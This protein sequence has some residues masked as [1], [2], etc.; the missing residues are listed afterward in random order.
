MVRVELIEYTKDGEKVVAQ[1]AKRTVSISKVSDD[2]VEKILLDAFKRGHWS[3]WEFSNYVFE[4]E[5]SRVCT[6]QLV[7]HRIASYSQTSQRYG[8]AVLKEFLRELGNAA[9]RPCDAS[10]YSCH[11]LNVETYEKRLSS[12]PNPVDEDTMVSLVERY[13][14]IP[15]SVKMN[16]EVRRGYVRTILESV[17]MYLLMLGSG[18]G[19]EDARYVLPQ[20]VVSRVVVQMNAR[21]LA[22]VFFPLR[23]C[24]RTQAELRAVAWRLWMKLESLHPLL[25]G[26][27]GPRC[28]FCENMVRDTPLKLRDVLDEDKPVEF[29]IPRCPEGVPRDRIRLCVLNTYKNT[30]NL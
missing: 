9:S 15:A 23:M 16:R 25:F 13:F 7:R 3:P 26:F 1:A 29:T 28:L 14:F 8:T 30:F 27:T 24:S 22:T 19:F 17:K 20:S 6:H 2:E 4:V 12:S 10:D 11:A 18:V 21:E 5:C